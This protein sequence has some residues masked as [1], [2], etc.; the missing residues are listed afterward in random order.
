M[1]YED[2]LAGIRRW[3][4]ELASSTDT[5][6]TEC[7][8]LLCAVDDL[9]VK[10]H[11][12]SN[13]EPEIIV[14]EY[15]TL[16]VNDET[17]VL[18]QNEPRRWRVIEECP[19]DVLLIES[20]DGEQRHVWT[21]DTCNYEEI[22]KLRVQVRQLEDMVADLAVGAA[23]ARAQVETLTQYKAG[24]MRGLVPASTRI[25]YSYVPEAKCYGYWIC[26]TPA[27]PQA[28]RYVGNT[29]EEAVTQLGSLAY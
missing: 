12:A 28:W 18:L 8:A 1:R 14:T 19:G 26:L 7:H 4:H 15:G 11:V 23:E 3:R 9:L 21:G 17:A 20:P 16:P 5:R 10:L 22:D 6:H 27:E 24:A 29:L 25:R 13:R 2:V